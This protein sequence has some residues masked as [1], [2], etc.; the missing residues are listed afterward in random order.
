MWG[1]CRFSVATLFATTLLGCVARPG[2]TL[3]ISSNVAGLDRLTI[4]VLAKTGALVVDE[5]HPMTGAPALPG[6]LFIDAGQRRETL[7]LLVWGERAGARVAFAAET[8]DVPHEATVKL[9][10]AAPPKDADLDGVPDALDGCPAT[11]DPRQADADADGIGDACACPDNRLP[12]PG[13]ETETTGWF[14]YLATASRVTP[15]LR[16]EGAARVCA[17]ADGQPYFTLAA[18]PRTITSTKAGERFQARGWLRDPSPR[19]GGTQRAEVQLREFDANGD[20]V[21][22][23]TSGGAVLGPEWAPFSVEYTTKSDGGTAEV[24]FGSL[25]PPPGACFEVDEVCVRRLP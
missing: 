12:N 23:A 25:S 4:T 9:V 15:G 1:M 6:T 10:L 2:V 3:E 13:F 21:D 16:G 18:T 14:P 7:R 11:N 24:F 19:D 8:V 17:E 20:D 22:S 5:P